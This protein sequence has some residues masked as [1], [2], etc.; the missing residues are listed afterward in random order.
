QAVRLNQHVATERERMMLEKHRLQKAAQGE[1]DPGKFTL[2]NVIGISR[3]MQ[4]VYAEIHQIAPSRSTV[5]LR[6]ESGTGK[7]LIARAVHHLS[8]RKAGPFIKVNCAALPETLLESELFGHEKGAFTGATQDRKGRFELAH[9]GTLFLDEI[10][11]I[12]ASFQAKLLRV[13]Q[14]GEFERVGGSRTVKVDVRIVAAT[15]RNLEEAVSKGDFRADLYYRINVVPIFLPALRERKDDIPLLVE[16][17]LDRFNAENKRQVILSSDAMEVLMNCYFPGNVRELEN[18]VL[19][20]ATMARSDVVHDIDLACQKGL[21]LSATLWKHKTSGIA[22]GGIAPCAPNSACVN[23]SCGERA[24]ASSAASAAF[25]GE[26]LGGLD[27]LPPGTQR[28][29]LLRAMETAGW[30]QAKAARILGLSPRQVGYA[31][32]KYNIEVKKM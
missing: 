1:P 21:C 10:G 14:E 17:F 31:L 23:T 25:D 26:S 32:R 19:R 20:L 18:C 27:D 2:S 6:G 13:L 5:L 11:E 7:E 12:S 15:N 29:R 24:T 28:E 30:V 22:S 4:D 9:N 3:R 16:H 8:T